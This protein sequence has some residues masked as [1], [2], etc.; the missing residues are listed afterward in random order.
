MSCGRVFYILD[1]AGDE[2]N[3]QEPVLSSS[4]AKIMGI[5]IGLSIDDHHVVVDF[6]Q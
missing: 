5:V 6:S 1:I 4:G 3:G 2:E